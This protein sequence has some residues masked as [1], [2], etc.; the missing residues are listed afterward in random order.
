MHRTPVCSIPVT[1]TPAPGSTGDDILDLVD[2]VTRAMGRPP[3][4]HGGYVWR[5]N[6]GAAV[7]LQSE[8]PTPRER[9][10]PC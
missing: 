9:R 3:R 4:Q 8:P 6:A 2:E 10:L 5:T 7:V 1:I